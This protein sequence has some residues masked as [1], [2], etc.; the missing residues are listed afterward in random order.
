M[1]TANHGRCHPMLQCGNFVRSAWEWPGSVWPGSVWV[2]MAWVSMGGKVWVGN[3]LVRN[4]GPSPNKLTNIT[5]KLTCHN[6]V[7][8]ID[9]NVGVVAR[10]NT[11]PRS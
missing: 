6:D 5:A 3:G 1:Q 9:T 4:L 7:V 11:G 10:R 2:G 8:M